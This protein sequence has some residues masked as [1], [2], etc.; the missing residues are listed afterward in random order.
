M[1][2]HYLSS[3]GGGH[4]DNILINLYELTVMGIIGLSIISAQ[5]SNSYD[6]PVKNV[7]YKLISE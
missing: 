2:I 6:R 7:D 4:D 3:V 1:I 5:L